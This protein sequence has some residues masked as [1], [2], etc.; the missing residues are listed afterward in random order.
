[1]RQGAVRSQAAIDFISSYGFALLIIAISIYAVL[2]L[3]VFNYS[4]S[5]PYCYPETPFSCVA[6]SMNTIGTLTIAIS[7]SSGGI[8]RITGAA[9]ATVTNTTRVGPR[10]GNV[11]VL[12]YL[13]TNTPS[14]AYPNNNLMGGV[15]LYPGSTLLLYVNCYS[16]NLGLASSSIGSTFTGYLWLNYTFSGL[17]STYH[18]V[19]R[20]ASINVKYTQ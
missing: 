15:V 20:A 6:Y 5:P 7:Q 12:P 4:A 8:L 16:G 17:P 13:A 1:M 10:Y 19:G 2:Q 11:N 14:S 18:A 9:C 3:G